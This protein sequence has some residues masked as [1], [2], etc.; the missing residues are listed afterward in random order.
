MNEKEMAEIA[1]ALRVLADKISPRTGN[2]SE[3]DQDE[4]YSP[5]LKNG[6]RPDWLYKKAL[7][8]QALRKI[9]GKSGLSKPPN[10]SPEPTGSGESV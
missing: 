2:V 3:T 4:S 6:K 5:P 9:E 7:R 1:D 10:K 8:E